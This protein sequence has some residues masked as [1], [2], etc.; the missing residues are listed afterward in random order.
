MFLLAEGD[1]K[2]G[3]PHGHG[4]FKFSE[5]D[6]L[7]EGEWRDGERHGT[8]TELYADGSQYTGAWNT[9]KQ[10]GN[11]VFTHFAGD[12]YAGQFKVLPTSLLRVQVFSCCE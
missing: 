10:N 5:D 12:K 9:G 1:F 2:N 6:S 11:G 4:K 3:S 7:Y 8:G